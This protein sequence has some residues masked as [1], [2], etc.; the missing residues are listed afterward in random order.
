MLSGKKLAL[1]YVAMTTETFGV[2]HMIGSNFRGENR[3]IDAGLACRL[4]SPSL[5]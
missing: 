1:L 2:S 4:D 3:Q 5:S